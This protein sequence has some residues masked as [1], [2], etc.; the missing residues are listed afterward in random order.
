MNRNQIGQT[1]GRGKMPIQS[2]T[3]QRSFCS[4]H[5]VIRTTHERAVDSFG[6]EDP[7]DGLI[8]QRPVAAAPGA[9]PVVDRVRVVCV[10][11]T[12]VAR[13][14]EMHFWRKI[15][16]RMK[17][18]DS[19]KCSRKKTSKI[20]DYFAAVG[21]LSKTVLLETF[22]ISAKNKAISRGMNTLEMNCFFPRQWIIHQ[23]L[24]FTAIIHR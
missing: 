14:E 3:R 5:R 12:A 21:D 16:N 1:Q 4:T 22:N 13:P 10:P 7:G 6:S 17:I 18:K 15:H 2:T 8:G 20:P 11:A 19:L 24:L 23:Q 9:L